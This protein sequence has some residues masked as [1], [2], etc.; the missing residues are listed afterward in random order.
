MTR[1][2]ASS[3]GVACL[4]AILAAALAGCIVTPYYPQQVAAPAP[5]L[6]DEGEQEQ[7]SEPPPPLP[8]YEQPPCP[9]EGY[10]WTPGLWRWGAEGYFWVPGTWVAPPQVG[11]LWT[12]GFWAVTGAVYVFHAG[13]WGNHVGYYGGINY[14]GGY[15]GS[16]YAGGRWSNNRFQY[17]TAVSNVNVRNVHNT[18][19]ETV[20]NNVAINN[21]TNVQRVSYVGATPARREP[22]RAELG[23]SREPHYAPTPPQAQHH[24]AARTNPMQNAA[25]N[26]GR[27]PVAATPRAGAFQEHGVTAAQPVG[28]AYRPQRAQGQPQRAQPERA[29]ENKG[30]EEERH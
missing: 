12:P 9:Q 29:P 2:S 3:A 14:G 26:E 16:G 27:P 28:P 13:H 7:A 19:N 23:A 30:R 21:N 22:T 17:N 10:I 15:T 5:P 8:V 18:Y 6:A 11:M 1:T 4:A 24:D 25:R 20:V